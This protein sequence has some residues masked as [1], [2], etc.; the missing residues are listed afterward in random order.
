MITPVSVHNKQ[1]RK[2]SKANAIFCEIE[3]GLTTIKLFSIKLFTVRIVKEFNESTSSN[4][5]LFLKELLK[6][7]NIRKNSVLIHIK[8]LQYLEQIN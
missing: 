4:Y 8:S 5:T 1:Y 7:L 3:M 6:S 2:L